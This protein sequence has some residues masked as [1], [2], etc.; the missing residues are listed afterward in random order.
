MSISSHSLL[1]KIEEEVMKAKQLQ[2]LNKQKQHV[3]TIKT[4]CELMLDQETSSTIE[5][6]RLVGSALDPTP[7]STVLRYEKSQPLKT[8]DGANGDSIF[9]F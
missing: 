6:P 1:K 7:T 8:D 9:D 5:N 4:L 3:Y 2:E